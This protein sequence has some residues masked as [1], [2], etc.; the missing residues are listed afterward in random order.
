[1]KPYRVYVTPAAWTEMRELPGH[2]RQ[3]TKQAVDG[4]ALEP[5][6]TSSKALTVTD[7][8]YEVRR[9]R[10]DRWRIVYL[11]D[12]NTHTLSVLTV[13]KRPPYNYQDLAELLRSLQ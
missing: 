5:R 9:A 11:I 7:T 10:L 2:I 6:P 13:R 1:M 4:L 12:E 8:P 3:R